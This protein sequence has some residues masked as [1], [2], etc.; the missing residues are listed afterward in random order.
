MSSTYLYELENT[1]V[2]LI[3]STCFKSKWVIVTE[4]LHWHFRR[5][6]RVSAFTICAPPFDPCSFVPLPVAVQMEARPCL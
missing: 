6:R 5:H 3:C 2:S 1:S 4:T